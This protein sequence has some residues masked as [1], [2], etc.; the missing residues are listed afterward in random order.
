[1]VNERPKLSEC[2]QRWNGT[3]T[4]LR[5]ACCI[6][7]GHPDGKLRF[8]AIGEDNE[9]ARH[10]AP[11]RVSAH[12]E[13]LSGERMPWVGYDH[14]RLMG[15]ASRVRPGRGRATWRAPLGH[16]ACR[17]GFSTRYF[18][19]SRVLGELAHARADGSYPKL[20]DKIA[21]TQL[22]VI[23]DFGL[24]PLTDDERRDLLEV[25]EDGYGRRAALVTSQL[26]FEHSA[27]VGARNGSSRRKLMNAW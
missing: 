20:L 2:T 10:T 25:L 18:R 5:V 19:F 12:C 11:P 6:A 26:P 27:A 1:M 17:R 16:S 7:F 15:I 21:R 14:R 3:L 9:I 4:N 8:R 13:L 22:L 24:S 23:D